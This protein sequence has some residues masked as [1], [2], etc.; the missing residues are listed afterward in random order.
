MRP[1]FLRDFPGWWPYAIGAALIGMA[2]AASVHVILRKRDVRAA[3][4]W[5]GLIWLVPGIGVLLYVMLGLNRIRTRATELQRDRRRLQLAT[6]SALSIA[7]IGTE[8]TVSPALKPLARLAEQMSGRPLLTG[9]L[10]AVLQDGDEAY[11]AMLDAIDGA[12]RSVALASYIFGDDA[13]GR[14]FVEALARAVKRGVEVRVLLDGVGVNYTWPPVYRHL[15][16]LGVRTALFLP[17]L[18][19]AGLAFFNLRN[20]RKMLIVD[21]RVAFT[22]GLNIQA[23]NINAD[24]PRHPVRDL[25]FR[26]EGPIVCQLQEAFAEDWAFTT[27]EILDGAPWYPTLMKVGT[28]TARVF[29][30]G[31]D[32]NLEILRT[33]L[34]GA[35]ASARQSVRIVTPYFL[36]DQATIAALGVAALRGV[37]VDI[38]LPERVNI[39]FV[40]WA[41]SAQLWQVLRPG[42]RVYYTPLP[43]DHTKLMLVDSEWVLL[44]SSNWDPRSLRLNFELDVECHDPQLAAQLE[45]IVES[46]IRGGRR[47]TLDE[48]DAR[49]PLTKIRD[50][51]ARLFSP[52]L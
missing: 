18:R 30:D 13:A 21:G 10:A 45:T 33:V 2:L 24:N 19:D 15:R 17:G 20:H 28:T 4:G 32:G 37:A 7:R 9:N 1:T 31:P 8:A 52:Y 3:I 36:P 43:F 38:V 22:G 27:R 51:L 14:P 48:M 47:I 44:G 23:R 5:V 41:A 46:R 42:C 40:K 35:L 11:P 16:R 6:P 26:L 12:R 39:P 29:T 34:M 50:G 49:R 25:H